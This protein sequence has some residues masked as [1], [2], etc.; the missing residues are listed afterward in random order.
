MEVDR[1]DADVDDNWDADRD[2]ACSIDLG[3]EPMKVDIDSLSTSRSDV[4]DESM[5]VDC[6]DLAQTSRDY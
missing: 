6:C 3:V 2:A 5:D 4:C 1:S